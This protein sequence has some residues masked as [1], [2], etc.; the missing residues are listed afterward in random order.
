MARV[1]ERSLPSSMSYHNMHLLSLSEDD[2]IP[3]RLR[4]L[5]RAYYADCQYTTSRDVDIYVKSAIMI[6]KKIKNAMYQTFLVGMAIL[7]I[8]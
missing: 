5:G 7:I 3:F 6:L 2:M 1:K 4:S 8:F